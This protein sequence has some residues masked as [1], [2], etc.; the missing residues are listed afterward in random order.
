MSD[1]TPGFCIHTHMQR[2]STVYSSLDGWGGGVGQTT[3]T[4]CVAIQSIQ[5]DQWV[6]MYGRL[7]FDLS[8]TFSLKSEEGVMSCFRNGSES[9]NIHNPDGMPSQTWTHFIHFSNIRWEKV[10]LRL[11]PKGISFL[12]YIDIIFIPQDVV[13]LILSFSTLLPHYSEAE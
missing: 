9:H 3:V 1:R 5:L 12:N 4:G 10:S 7:C 11:H 8:M 2:I 13:Y 6:V